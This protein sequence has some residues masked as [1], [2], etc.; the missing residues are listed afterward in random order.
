MDGK[1]EGDRIFMILGKWLGIVLVDGMILSVGWKL[2][3]AL[4]KLLGIEVMDGL[5]LGINVVLGFKLLLGCNDG[6]STIKN[7]G[8]LVPVGCPV[9]YQVQVAVGT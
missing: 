6:F 7:M 1:R 3:N 8:K 9:G 2:G 5:E 4:R